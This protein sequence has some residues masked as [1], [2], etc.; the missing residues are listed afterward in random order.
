MLN[1]IIPLQ[2]LSSTRNCLPSVDNR[3][4]FINLIHSQEN[5]SFI[6]CRD[7]IKPELFLRINFTHNTLGITQDTG[8][9][10]VSLKPMSTTR[11]DWH[12]MVK[13]HRRWLGMNTTCDT[14]S[15]ITK[16][17]PQ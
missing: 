9:T 6:C 10:S 5:Y 13:V 17:I 3:N 15:V 12:P 16:L 11:A 2:L 1:I 14:C 4:S 8:R 7:K